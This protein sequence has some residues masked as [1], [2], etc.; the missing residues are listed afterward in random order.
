LAPPAASAQV[1]PNVVVFMTDDQTVS[2]VNYMPNVRRLIA[3][4]GTNFTRQFATFPLCCPS[5][6]TFLTGQYAHNHGVLHNAGNYGGYKRLDHTNTLP[7]WLQLAG[8]RTLMVGRYLNGYGTENL[9]QTEIPP[10]WNEWFVPVGTSAQAFRNQTINENGLL[11]W[12]SDYQT[13]LY[14]NKAL[15]LINRTPSPF[16]LYL[17]FSAPHTGT[18]T[19]PD[20]PLLMR[21]PSPAPRHRNAFANAELPQPPNFNEAAIGDKPQDVFER[22]LLSPETQAAMRENWQQ[23]LESLLSVDEA[24]AR[25]IEGLRASGQLDNTLIVFTSDNGFEHGEHRIQRE[26]VWP[27]DESARVPLLIRGPGVPRN[28]KLNQLT[29]NID[30]APTILDAAGASP[31]LAPD[32]RSLFG[33][34][35]DR[36]REW[37]REILLESGYGA[38]AVG[39]YAGIRNYR[40]LYVAWSHSGEYELYD[41]RKDPWQLNNLDGRI[42]Y[43]N[44]QAELARRLGTLRSCL[45]AGCRRKPSL[46]LSASCGK[47]RRVVR[48]GGAEK[49]KVARVDFFAGRRRLAAD[50]RAPFQAELA[51]RRLRLRARATLRYGRKLTLD[52]SLLPC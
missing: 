10:G 42:A 8:Y 26:K 23:E 36:T 49:A 47:R 50:R 41:L 34:M 48:L 14:A 25:V 44:V 29:G 2:Q 5:R 52:R 20:D 7:L 38:N 28:L 27:Y 32:G 19:D 9:N 13:D 11:R 22:P 51:P 1:P 46:R 6:A 40:Y 31:G 33:L 30:V 17:S 43:E 18:P 4:E 35:E 37:G 45:G 15:E 3:R 16:F 12:F 39:G 24:V 21:T